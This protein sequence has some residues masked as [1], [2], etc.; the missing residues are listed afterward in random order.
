MIA[1]VVAAVVVPLLALRAG[2]PIWL[3]VLI[4]IGVFHIMRSVLRPSAPKPPAPRVD[5]QQ[6]EGARM[7]NAQALITEGW[8]AHERLRR[9]TREVQDVEM[10]TELRQLTATSGRVLEDLQDDP[11]KAMAVRRLLTFY[12]PNAASVAEGWRALEGRRLPAPECLS[13]TRDTVRTLNEA[14]DRFADELVQPQMQALDLDLKVLNDALK[15][16]LDRTR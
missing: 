6:L 14:F 11:S 4:A 1:G 5:V 15:A 10:R 3:A 8:A 7:E 2:L 16:D 12:L 13:Q 9:T